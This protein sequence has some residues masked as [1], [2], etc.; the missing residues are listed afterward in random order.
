MSGLGSRNVCG[1]CFGN[2]GLVEFCETYGEAKRCDFCGRRKRSP[3]A[4]P[5]SDVLSHVRDTI[6]RHYDDP[7]NA[8]LAYESAEGG[9]QGSTFDTDDVF[10]SMGLDFSEDRTDT[11]RDL[12]AAKLGND[13]WT[14][15]DPYGLTEQDHLGYSW[16]GFC[17]YIKHERRY[18]F[19]PGRKERVP[20]GLLS[21]ADL[22]ERIFDYAH[23]AGAFVVLPSGAR[24]HRARRQKR[25]VSL[26]TASELGPPPV[27]LAIQPNRM[28]P[29]GIVMIYAADERVTALAEVAFESGKYA[30]GVF[31]TLRD[32]LIL[33][34]TDLPDPPSI[35]AEIPDYFEYDPR[36]RMLFLHQISSEI[37]R[38]IVRD[39]RTPI[40]YVPTQI[41][42]EYLRSAV[43]IDGRKVDGLRYRS[44]RNPKG[45]S[46]VLFA[47]RDNVVLPLIER[48]EWY[49]MSEDRWLN[50]V[51]TKVVRV[52]KKVLTHYRAAA[53]L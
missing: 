35:F 48:G 28:S 25:G 17:R 24:L 20:S 53:D 50:L 32:A 7:A 41:V 30:T 5:L 26:T 4:A 51:S 19:M 23:A 37:S 43:E 45:T 27:E 11:L 2:A 36:P 3:F 10:D 39:G 52:S 16:E 42:T 31:E 40:E 47:D 15:K 8:G 13:L 14:D 22:L 12:V 1:H 9:Y 49:N 6:Y 29:A 44:A 18:F 46:L 34:L 33:D 38:P 21:P